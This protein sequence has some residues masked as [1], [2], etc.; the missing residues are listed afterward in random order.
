MF[1]GAEVRLNE[2]EPHPGILAAAGKN[3]KKAV[4]ILFAFLMLLGCAIAQTT[5]KP[6]DVLTIGCVEEP[7]L[8]GEYNV[9]AQGIILM[10]F[11][12]AVEVN[13][14]TT[15]QAAERIS[16]TLTTQQI[17]KTAT[18]TVQIKQKEPQTVSFSGA[19][20]LPGSL[21]YREGLSVADVVKFAQ[22]TDTADLKAVRLRRKDG[23]TQTIDATSPD[24]LGFLLKVGDDLFFAVKPLGG[25]ITVLGAVAKPGLIALTTGMKLS[26]AIKA[27]GGLRTDADRHRVELRSGTSTKSYDLDKTADEPSLQA[28]D[29][30]V[31]SVRPINEKV[32]VTGAV[33]N[34]GLVQHEPG[35]TALKV[36]EDAQPMEKA[37]IDKVRINRKEI[38]KKPRTITV[39]LK[40]VKAGTAPD[41]ELM[42]GDTIEVPYPA[43]ISNRTGETLKYVAVGLLLFFVL[44]R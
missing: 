15:T 8:G 39:N 32:F 18:I 34:P 44:R 43:M 27:A 35:M 25:D 14:L 17:L 20:A 12:G 19:L 16:K 28:G 37:R 11:I 1:F 13:G 10:Q 2:W 38:D 9:T 40:K 3:M 41:V 36:V 22:P 42:N 26:D 6:G 33:N 23:G 24:G 5:I 30:V 31:V 7:K 4:S 21:E 29:T